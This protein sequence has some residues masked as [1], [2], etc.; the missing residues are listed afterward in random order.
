MIN[1]IEMNKPHLYIL[2]I[3]N[4]KLISFWF[5]HKFGKMQ[6]GLFP[7]FKI[8]ELEIFPI[9]ETAITDEENLIKLV[10]RRISGDSNVDKQIDE[11]VYKLY[12]LSDEEIKFIEKNI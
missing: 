8:N 1:I 4:S 7:Q 6:R 11:Y 5:I 2:G 10:E 9:V 3:L 12:E